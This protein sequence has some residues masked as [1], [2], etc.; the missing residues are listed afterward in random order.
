[1]DVHGETVS[2]ATFPVPIW[3]LYM[4]AAEKGKPVRQFLTPNAEPT[5]KYFT[6]GYWGYV[7]V[8]TLPTTSTS[9]PKPAKARPLTPLEQ[10]IQLVH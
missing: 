9:T 8:P 3:H 2:G 5:Y 1:L 7:A 4:A 6:K 10:G